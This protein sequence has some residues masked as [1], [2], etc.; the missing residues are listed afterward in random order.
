MCYFCFCA[1]LGPF[2]SD[3]SRYIFLKV[4]N[5]RA[6]GN[7]F[8]LRPHLCGL[9]YP[10]QPSPRVTLAE[11]TFSLFLCKRQPFPLGSRTRLGGRD[12]SMTH[13]F[14]SFR[15]PYLYPSEGHKHGVSIQSLRNLS[16]TFLRI[17]P[18][19]NIAQT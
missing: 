18:A 2:H 5:S 19:R 11:G 8:S 10:R 15:P 12:N 7:Y 6:Y 4:G 17:S 14:D 16:K 9:G 3:S 13:V 1:I